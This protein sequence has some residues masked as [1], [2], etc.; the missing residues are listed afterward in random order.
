MAD[1][2]KIINHIP[3][4]QLLELDYF[5]NRGKRFLSRA[6]IDDAQ[7]ERERIFSDVIKNFHEGQG[8]SLNT[9]LETDDEEIIE[10]AFTL[11]QWLC[12]NVGSCVLEEALLGIG[13][14]VVEVKQ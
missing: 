6:F 14:K 4:Q 5:K 11:F 12:T 9:V 2:S 13:K 7:G 8:A 3:K 1:I 10:A